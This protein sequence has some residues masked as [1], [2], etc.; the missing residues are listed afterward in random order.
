MKELVWEFKR[1]LDSLLLL[2]EI[3]VKR[4]WY[5]MFWKGLKKT[6]IFNSFRFLSR[7]EE[8][9]RTGCFDKRSTFWPNF[10]ILV[11]SISQASVSGPE[12]CSWNTHRWEISIPL[13]S[14]GGEDWV[15]GCNI[16]LRCRWTTF[17]IFKFYNEI[18]NHSDKTSITSLKVT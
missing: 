12:C 9:V 17:F 8:S 10:I 6:F 7:T 18:E 1:R 15:V 2:L 14:Q 16:E 3:P 5:R 13:S 11:S 4:V